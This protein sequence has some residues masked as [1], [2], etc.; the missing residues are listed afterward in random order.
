LAPAIVCTS[1]SKIPF[2]LNS[3]AAGITP[4][5]RTYHAALLG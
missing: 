1:I 5:A 2:A 3:R 4:C